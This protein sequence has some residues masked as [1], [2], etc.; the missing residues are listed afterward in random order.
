MTSHI[1]AVLSELEVTT[2]LLSGLNVAWFTW[3]P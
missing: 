3:L 2:R 1:R